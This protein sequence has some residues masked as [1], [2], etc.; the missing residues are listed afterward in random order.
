M[1]KAIGQ[2][3]F[4]SESDKSLDTAQ[5]NSAIPQDRSLKANY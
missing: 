5:V 4:M 1:A 3:M 2:S